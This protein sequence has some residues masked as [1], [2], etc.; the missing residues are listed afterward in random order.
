VVEE[1]RMEV[2]RWIGRKWIGIRAE[3]GFD[4]LEGWAVKEISDR[5]HPS[6]SYYLFF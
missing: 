1:T 2:L 4:T 6:L 5:K 3:K